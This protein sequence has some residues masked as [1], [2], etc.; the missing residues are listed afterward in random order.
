MSFIFIHFFSSISQTRPSSALPASEPHK[1]FLSILRSSR[2]SDHC[3]LRLLKPRLEF[4]EE[5]EE[6]VLKPNSC[7]PARSQAI[8]SPVLPSDSAPMP[9]KRQAL[10][11]PARRR[12]STYFSSSSSIFPWFLPLLPFRRED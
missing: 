2:F 7:N 4:D 3:L 9:K 8:P 11:R 1:A 10:P 12:P 5:E 6:D